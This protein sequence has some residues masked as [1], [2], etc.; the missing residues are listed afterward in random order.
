[1]SKEKKPNKKDTHRL[2]KA[3]L[4]A[5]SL[6]ILATGMVLTLTAHRPGKYKPTAPENPDVVSPY[7]THELGPGFYN[8]VQLDQPFE[9]AVDQVGLNDILSREK[10]PMQLDGLALSMP[11]VLFNEGQITFMVDV[12]YSGLS[13]VVSLIMLPE[14]DER[15][16]LNLNI[17][18]VY[19]GAMPITPLAKAIASN[20]A[21]QYLPE[22][23][24]QINPVETVINAILSNQPFDPVLPIGQYTVRLEKLTLEEGRCLLF[25]VPVN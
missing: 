1:M 9:L 2:R 7:L 8:Q 13:A 17:Q 12:D 3:M 18:T 5:L 16:M 10:W 21:S 6:L 14:I 4:V 19:L 20:I 24:E 15:G 11:T 23:S 22:T 25:L